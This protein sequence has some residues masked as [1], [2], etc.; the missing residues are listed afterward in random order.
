MKLFVLFH[1]VSAKG[2]VWLNVFWSHFGAYASGADLTHLARP[3]MERGEPGWK[4]RLENRYRMFRHGDEIRDLVRQ[5]LDPDGPNILIAYALN[6]N[7][8]SW[9]RVLRPV[10]QMFDHRVL[11]IFDSVFPEDARAEDIAGF[12]RIT[13]FCKDLGAVFERATGVRALYWPAH[14]DVLNFHCIG[15]YRPV[16]LIVVGRRDR[17]LHGPLHRHFND[18]ARE[19][20]FLDF[21][22]RTQMIP[23]CEEE[24]RLLMSMYGKSSASFC[25]EASREGRFRGHSPLMGRWVHA[26]A[27]GCTVLGRRPT[28]S[29]VAEQ[30][31]WPDSMIELG[32]DPAEAI[33]EVEGVLADEQGLCHRRRRNVV[34]ALRRHD[35]RYRLRDLLLDLGLEVP[36]RLQEGLDALSTRA[37]EIDNE[38]PGN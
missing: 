5:N 32:E 4:W 8:I 15:D 23:T 17:A 36:V 12:D 25:F 16:D 11:S 35:T 34:E 21:R 29:G 37:C 14:I 13:C 1:D 3:V 31:D 24:F 26:W 27:A 10:W 38:A 33:A 19:R 9:T 30:M 2:P 28:G 6:G 20:L 22:T 7:D 18:P